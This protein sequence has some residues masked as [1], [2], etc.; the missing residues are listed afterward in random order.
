MASAFI[1]YS[2]T[3]SKASSSASTGSSFH[4]HLHSEA[5]SLL[6]SALPRLPRAYTSKH[7]SA[8][9][10]ECTLLVASKGTL[11][12]TR[13]TAKT[14]SDREGVRSHRDHASAD[15][16]SVT[17]AA[18]DGASDSDPHE[19]LD[20]GSDDEV[21]AREGCSRNTIHSKDVCYVA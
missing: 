11:R 18:D 2:A 4:N 17:N 15:A 19:V 13:V 6:C 3:F 9:G 8:P 21:S 1:P 14:S 10:C 12:G 7:V 16:R 5:L 20:E